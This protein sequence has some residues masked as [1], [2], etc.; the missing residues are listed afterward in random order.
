LPPGQW[1]VAFI[2]PEERVAHPASKTSNRTAAVLFI[3]VPWQY[4]MAIGSVGE[5]DGK[6]V[7]RAKSPWVCTPP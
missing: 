3:Q 4:E 6:T 7:W 2:W 1:A 5:S